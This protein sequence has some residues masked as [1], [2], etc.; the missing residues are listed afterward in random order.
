MF[1]KASLGPGTGA[2]HKIYDCTERILVR[3]LAKSPRMTLSEVC[4][5]KDQII[6]NAVS[7]VSSCRITL[8]V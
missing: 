2:A 7:S 3:Q 1:P 4:T 6:G 5:V 8:L